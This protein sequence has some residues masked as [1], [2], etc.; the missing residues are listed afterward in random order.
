MNDTSLPVRLDKW[1]WAARF[2]KT[3]RIATDAIDAGHIRVNGQKAKASRDLRCGDIITITRG[4]L[5][6]EIIVR[7]LET[8]RGPA[9]IARTLYEETPQSALARQRHTETRALLPAAPDTR[10]TKR[11]RRALERLRRSPP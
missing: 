1:L 2:Y 6:M 9:P 11:D 4:P 3:R 7:A 5:E 8:L 10:P